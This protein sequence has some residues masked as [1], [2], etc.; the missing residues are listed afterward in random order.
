[1]GQSLSGP[2][3]LHEV[4]RVRPTPSS[5]FLASG[6]RVAYHRGVIQRKKKKTE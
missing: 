3:M 1:M 4:H 6:V 5:S 2:K